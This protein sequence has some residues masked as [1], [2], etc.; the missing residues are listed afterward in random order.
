MKGWMQ[1]GKAIQNI[2][3][4]AVAEGVMA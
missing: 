3:E 2:S 4:G 1:S